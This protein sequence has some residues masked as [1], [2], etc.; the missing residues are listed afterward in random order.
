MQPLTVM[1][2]AET[3]VPKKLKP[4]YESAHR[5]GFRIAYHFTPFKTFSHSRLRNLTY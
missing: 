4:H 2:Y 3:T 1:R 5:Y